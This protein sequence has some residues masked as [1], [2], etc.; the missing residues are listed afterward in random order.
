MDSLKSKRRPFGTNITNGERHKEQRSKSASASTTSPRRTSRKRIKRPNTRKETD[1][2]IVDTDQDA[3]LI[4]ASSITPKISNASKGSD[5]TLSSALAQGTQADP[6]L[7]NYDKVVPRSSKVKLTP[8]R[9][10]ANDN[11]DESNKKRKK[12]GVAYLRSKKVKKMKEAAYPR[13]TTP[14]H[15]MPLIPEGN[16]D[17]MDC[18][19]DDGSLG[20]FSLSP[21]KNISGFDKD[22]SLIP[23]FQEARQISVVSMAPNQNN[24]MESCDSRSPTL[25]SSTKIQ[26]YKQSNF[27]QLFD[28]PAPKA[29]AVR[30]TKSD[31]LDGVG[32]I[33]RDNKDVSTSSAWKTSNHE[34]LVKE[35]SCRDK[36]IPAFIKTPNFSNR[37]IKYLSTHRTLAPNFQETFKG[38]D[39]S[40]TSIAVY[41][42]EYDNDITSLTT[43]T[44][45]KRTKHRKCDV[46][47]QASTV[48]SATAAYSEEYVA[49]LVT[50]PSQPSM[51]QAK[52]KERDEDCQAHSVE[53][54]S[55]SCMHSIQS[56]IR[57]ED[58]SIV[59]RLKEPSVSFSEALQ[60][61]YFEVGGRLIPHPPLPPGW[62]IRVSESKNRPFYCH[63][64][65]GTTWHCP[66]VLPHF[67]APA[68]IQIN[69][70]TP[71]STRSSKFSRFSTDSDSVL[72]EDAATKSE[73]RDEESCV[74]SRSQMSCYYSA[75][76]EDDLFSVDEQ[77]ASTAPSTVVA[78]PDD[79]ISD[80]DDEPAQLF[81]EIGNER[82]YQIEA[83]RGDGEKCT[84]SAL[85]KLSRGMASFSF[86][87]KIQSLNRESPQSLIAATARVQNRM[88]GELLS[89]ANSTDQQRRF[90]FN[91]SINPQSEITTKNISAWK[92]HFCEGDFPTKGDNHDLDSPN[93]GVVCPHFII[94]KV[95]SKQTNIQLNSKHQDLLHHDDV[96]HKIQ[97]NGKEYSAKSQDVKVLHDV[98]L[99]QREVV[100]N[101][102]L[103]GKGQNHNKEFHGELGEHSSCGKDNLLYSISAEAGIV[104]AHETF[105]SFPLDY[106][107]PSP[108]FED[109]FSPPVIALPLSSQ[110]LYSTT[111]SSKGTEKDDNNQERSYSGLARIVGS[112][113]A[114]VSANAL[115]GLNKSNQ[116]ESNQHWGEIQ[117][118]DRKSP[119]SSLDDLA[120]IADT[121]QTAISFRI[122]E[123]PHPLCILQ[124][125]DSIQNARSCMIIT[126][127]YQRKTPKSVYAIERSIAC[128][129]VQELM[130]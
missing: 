29:G 112:A 105:E 24:R 38:C 9:L 81:P 56:S 58:G 15:K 100:A 66:V 95:E 123:P 43:E 114:E 62:K 117:H 44:I 35:E 89:L 104:Q 51:K 61:V 110:R 74:S 3:F 73:A 71:K 30:P 33:H 39:F 8:L 54:V 42:D 109:N 80:P 98:N 130:F 31:T 82:P 6:F 84:P 19:S 124:R 65:H 48:E 52:C 32:R 13:P 57:R 53:S 34:K 116:G 27:Q 16:N 55:V 87:M 103:T 83:H 76:A 119:M 129:I 115:E 21:A 72:G 14:V 49:D 96:E 4:Q 12:V 50:P 93:D 28:S 126:K 5:R 11:V 47:F 2:C 113:E 125:L 69:S 85:E 37:N 107:S 23:K 127:G 45:V 118:P 92:A 25:K 22:G 59:V 94:A 67:H 120:S 121:N 36:G 86:P 111:K 40:P 41:S 1:I 88:R 26:L 46:S 97:M 91:Q 68:A 17:T 77:T 79:S 60:M 10:N 99:C 90:V 122:R 70:T 64:D 75:D 108:D 102:P 128:S 18:E 20:S 101:L 78:S 63:P 106:G 7:G